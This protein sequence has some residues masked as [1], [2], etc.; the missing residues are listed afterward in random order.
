MKSTQCLDEGEMIVNQEDL[1]RGEPIRPPQ[2]EI[3]GKY[4]EKVYFARGPI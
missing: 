3:R 4:R 1:R 2:A